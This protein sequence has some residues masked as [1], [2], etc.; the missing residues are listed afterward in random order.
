MCEPALVDTARQLLTSGALCFLLS[1]L[2]ALELW[3][4]TM[5]HATTFNQV[6]PLTTHGHGGHSARSV[7]VSRISLCHRLLP[8]CGVRSRS[9]VAV[10]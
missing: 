3:V 2:Q 10:V 4:A 6:P 8:C 9:S 1:P 7:C 5:Q